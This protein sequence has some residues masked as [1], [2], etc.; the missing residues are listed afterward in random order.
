MF[1]TSRSRCGVPTGLLFRTKTGQTI[2]LA[3]LQPGQ[4]VPM[5]VLDSL[6]QSLYDASQSLR[7]SGSSAQ[8]GYDKVRQQLIG[9]LEDRSPK[10][11][12]K[13]AYSMA[14]EKWAGPSQMRD[15]AEIGA[16]P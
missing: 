15:A 2:D 3:R 16:K 6:K 10:V 11:G 4:A 7:Q 14:M 9:V 12:G 5:N 1:S 8:A 13:S